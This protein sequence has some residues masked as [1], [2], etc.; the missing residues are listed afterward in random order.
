MFRK[1]ESG[2][3]NLPAAPAVLLN[4]MMP[5]ETY[6]NIVI[7]KVEKATG[8]P[9]E[10]NGIS[11]ENWR[12]IAQLSEVLHSV[13]IIEQM[14]MVEVRSS[15]SFSSRLSARIKP[16][17]AADLNS[18]LSA[19]EGVKKMI[20]DKCTGI[21]GRILIQHAHPGEAELKRPTD[22]NSSPIRCHACG[23]NITIYGYNEY[24][25]SKCGL[26]YSAA[27]YLNELKEGL[28]RI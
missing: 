21:A 19:L 13:M 28:E 14:V 26:G 18:S 2:Q 17:K 12:S 11:T 16:S 23:G 22:S 24:K 15:R 6:R 9:L 8:F 20:W 5:K 7:E 3:G 27:D 10:E 25:C 4:E 1:T